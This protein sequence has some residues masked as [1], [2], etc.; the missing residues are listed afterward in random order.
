MGVL[1]LSELLECGIYVIINKK[2][3]MVYVGQTQKNFLVRWIEHLQRIE[4]QTDDLHKMQLYLDEHT[5]FLVI[6]KIEKTNVLDFY[7]FESEA[8]DFYQ[9]KGWLVL[10]SKTNRTKI[11][12]KANSSSNKRERKLLRYVAVFLGTANVKENYVG[13]L[14]AGMYQK[15][16]K[17]FSTNVKERAKGKGVIDVLTE[18]EINYALLDFYP[19]YKAKKIAELKKIYGI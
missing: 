17:E 10:S 16:D 5:Q 13:R 7:K 3:K 18:A 14:L 1:S 6:K 11:G 2:L 4:E 19:R 15:I 12:E 9:E 8:M